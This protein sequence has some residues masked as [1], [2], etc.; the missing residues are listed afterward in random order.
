MNFSLKKENHFW[1]LSGIL[2]LSYLTYL[3]FIQIEHIF[4]YKVQTTLQMIHAFTIPVIFYIYLN[5]FEKSAWKWKIW[6]TIRIVDF[7]N[8]SGTYRGKF[9]SS[10]KDKDGKP[11]EGDMKLSISQTFSQICIQGVFNQSESI[12]IQ[13]FFA[14]NDFKQK[15]CLYYFYKNKPSNNAT[16]TMHTHE[17]STVLCFDPA[18]QTLSGEYYSGRD[19]NN[20]GDIFVKKI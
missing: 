2:I 8:L 1:F 13:A 14:F 18:D 10:F 5:W 15:N 19:R 16:P 20:H 7:P 6:T 3:L 4:P 12:S 11:F 17:G 9:I